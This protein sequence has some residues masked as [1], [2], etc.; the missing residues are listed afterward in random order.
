MLNA[1]AAFWDVG[2]S[3]S[4]ESGAIMETICKQRFREACE[5]IVNAERSQNGIGTLGE[6]TLHAV[7]KLYLEPDKTKHEIRI[8][9]YVADIVTD[10]GIIEIQTRAFNQLRNKLAV[11]L[12]TYAVT[13]VYPIPRTKWLIWIDQPTGENASLGSNAPL[14]G[15]KKKRK[16]PKRG[17]IHD[18]IPELYKIKSLLDHPNLHLCIILVDIEEYRYLNG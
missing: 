1:D 9:A 10:D 16:S 14:E 15:V 18:A 8:G 5:E 4:D 11:F 13:L 6:K 3:T 17:Q 12:E 2:K 7:I